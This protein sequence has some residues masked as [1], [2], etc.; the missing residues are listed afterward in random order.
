M[1][2]EDLAKLCIDC[3][4]ALAPQYGDTLPATVRAELWGGTHSGTPRHMNEMLSHSV[5]IAGLVISMVSLAVTLM[6]RKGQ[7]GPV[8]IGAVEQAIDGEI[9]DLGDLQKEPARKLKREICEWLQSR[10]SA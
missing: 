4:E 1:N 3:A 9:E 8:A 6:D 7:S 2:H 5:D 10:A